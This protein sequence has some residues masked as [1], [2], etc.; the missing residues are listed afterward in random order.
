MCG[1]CL[2]CLLCPWCIQDQKLLVFNLNSGFLCVLEAPPD[3]KLFCPKAGSRNQATFRKM[4]F[5]VCVTV[6]RIKIKLRYQRRVVGKGEAL[7]CWCRYGVR[8]LTLSGP[9]LG[10]NL[11]LGVPKA[12]KRPVG[13]SSYGFRS[14]H[15]SR[16]CAFPYGRRHKPTPALPFQLCDEPY[17]GADYRQFPAPRRFP[18]F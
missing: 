15:E 13:W 18:R 7:R 2:I 5:A 17:F 4:N 10:N 16:T 6:T 3:F 8:N 1:W 14:L 9:F 12:G 11:S